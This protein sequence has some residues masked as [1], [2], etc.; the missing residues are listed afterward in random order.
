MKITSASVDS[1]QNIIFIWL[2]LLGVMNNIIHA[3]RIFYHGRGLYHNIHYLRYSATS[4]SVLD[5][6]EQ[7]HS[8]TSLRLIDCII[9]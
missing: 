2:L 9:K 1:I 5:L 8:T 7:Q 3:D 6:V 4:D